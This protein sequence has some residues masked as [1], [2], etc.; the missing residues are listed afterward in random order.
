MPST[1]RGATRS[2]L[3][4]LGRLLHL[5]LEGHA[6]FVLTQTKG[7]LHELRPSGTKQ[8]QPASN[9]LQSPSQDSHT[10]F[11]DSESTEFSGC[12]ETCACEGRRRS[13]A[14]PLPPASA[15]PSKLHWHWQDPRPVGER[16]PVP[17][18]PAGEDTN[19]CFLA[20]PGDARAEG[21][22]P[23]LRVHSFLL[24]PPSCESASLPI[25]FSSLVPPS[26]ARPPFHDRQ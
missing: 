18:T 26:P 19:S 13:A 25:P 8:R 17:T 2:N 6:A 9:G 14:P 24:T 10:D 15:S 20:L 7:R 23:P 22:P 12:C 4:P 16:P 21:R 1:A 3:Q 11:L 5:F